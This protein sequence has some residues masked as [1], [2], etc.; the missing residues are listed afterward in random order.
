MATAPVV[1]CPT[2]KKPV[3]WLASERFKPF[4]SERCQLIDLGDW[5]TEAHKIPGSPTL[6]DAFED[7]TALSDPP[8]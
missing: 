3:P 1:A 2:C 4:C 8:D 7:K 6:D 5:A